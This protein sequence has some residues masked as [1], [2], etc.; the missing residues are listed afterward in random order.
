MSKCRYDHILVAVEALKKYADSCADRSDTL[1]I[2]KAAHAALHALEV[3]EKKLV[4]NAGRTPGKAI[5]SAIAEYDAKRAALTEATSSAG[6]FLR[7][8]REYVDAVLTASLALQEMRTIS[9]ELASIGKRL[10]KRKSD[11]SQPL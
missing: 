4:N 8:N 10:D 1:G 7:D 3:M 5:K 6:A 9:A 2:L 11:L